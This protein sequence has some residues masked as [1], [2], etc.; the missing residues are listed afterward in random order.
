MTNLTTKAGKLLLDTIKADFD[1]KGWVVG[2]IKIL[3]FLTVTIYLFLW[4]LQYFNVKKTWIK[5]FNILIFEYVFPSVQLIFFSFTAYKFSG[6]FMIKKGYSVYDKFKV[7]I[8]Y[9]SILSIIQVVGRFI[10]YYGLQQ[11]DNKRFNVIQMY[12]E[13]TKD[14]KTKQIDACNKAIRDIQDTLKI[15]VKTAGD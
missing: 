4:L 13:Q 5:N 6:N 8:F 3:L 1:N 11:L 14:A 7:L 2:F 12:N 10:E 9:I 15:Q